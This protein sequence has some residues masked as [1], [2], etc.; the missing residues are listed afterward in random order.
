[1]QIKKKTH[2]EQV[3]EIINISLISFCQFFRFQL[4]AKVERPNTKQTDKFLITVAY[5]FTPPL[6]KININPLCT[7]QCYQLDYIMIMRSPPL[8][9]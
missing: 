2:R 4:I 8:R 3:H 1:M 5:I 7:S 9:K 6:Y